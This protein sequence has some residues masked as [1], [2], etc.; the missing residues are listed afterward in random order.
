M[1][2]VG[3]LLI[4]SIL[5]KTFLNFFCT[6]QV[7]MF[8]VICQ[9]IYWIIFFYYSFTGIKIHISTIKVKTCR[10]LKFSCVGGFYLEKKNWPIFSYYQFIKLLL[11]NFRITGFHEQYVYVTVFQRVKW[12]TTITF[13]TSLTK[14]LIK[15]VLLMY[16]F[17][18]Q[19]KIPENLY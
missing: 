13:S 3:K 12:K 15:S 16:Q 9:V 7:W 4:W 1:T 6:S 5:N 11:S 8:R 2:F 17:K 18:N 10:M 14:C 19:I